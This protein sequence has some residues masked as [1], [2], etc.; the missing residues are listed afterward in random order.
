MLLKSGAEMSLKNSQMDQFQHIEKNKS[1]ICFLARSPG[2][3]EMT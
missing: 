2:C 3:Q 1:E